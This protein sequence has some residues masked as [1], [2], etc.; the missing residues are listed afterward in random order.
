MALTVVKLD[1]RHTGS[2]SF[3]Y[4]V[5]FSYGRQG[6]MF[7]EARAWATSQWGPT[8]EVDIWTEH[9]DLRNSQWSWER[10]ITNKVNKCRIFLATDKEANWFALRW[11]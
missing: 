7:A 5:E 8:V 1:R 11:S 6:R 10:T 4:A 3:V 2:G 9:P